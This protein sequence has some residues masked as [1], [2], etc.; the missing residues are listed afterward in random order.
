MPTQP[1]LGPYQIAITKQGGVSKIACFAHS[2]RCGYVNPNYNKPNGAFV[3]DSRTYPITAT[4]DGWTRGGVNTTVSNYSQFEAVLD[5]LTQHYLDIGGGIK[6]DAKPNRPPIGLRLS[7][8][9]GSIK[10]T[11]NEPYGSGTKWVN[12][13]TYATASVYM[14]GCNNGTQ[15]FQGYCSTNVY[16]A[17]LNDYII[18]DETMANVTNMGGIWA[19]MNTVAPYGGGIRLYWGRRNL[20]RRENEYYPFSTYGSPS[21]IEINFPKITFEFVYS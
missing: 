17:G 18:V 21:N 5:A 15:F 9:K 19:A 13:E 4:H 20:P 16:D 3:E 1:S 11:G 2:R 12:D 10:Y 6:F 7:S 14:Y 8:A